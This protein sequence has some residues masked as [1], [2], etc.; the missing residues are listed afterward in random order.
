MDFTQEELVEAVER[1]VAGLLE[2]AGAAEPPVDALRIAEHHLGIP[3][4]EEEPEEDDH[5]GRKKMA[6]LT[7]NP[8]FQRS[9]LVVG[10]LLR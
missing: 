5:H 8:R 2:R 4:T 3:V 1:L 10:Q 6:Q 7:I 9:V